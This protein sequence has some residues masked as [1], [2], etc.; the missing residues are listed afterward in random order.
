MH[1]YRPAN[2]IFDGPI[3]NLL[4]ILCI[5][6]TVHT[7]HTVLTRM[8]KKALMVQIWHFHW[9][10]SERRRSKHGSERVNGKF[11][12]IQG[13]R[14]SP[15]VRTG[16]TKAP[17]WSLRALLRTL[18]LDAIR[19]HKRW[20]A[21][22]E[23]VIKPKIVSLVESPRWG[24]TSPGVDSKWSSQLR[25]VIW[26]GSPEDDPRTVEVLFNSPSPPFYCCGF[27]FLLLQNTSTL[28]S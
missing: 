23:V 20:Y 27:C 12:S 26:P 17:Q 24:T 15:A 28:P 6:N 2:N 3:T 11:R 9:S 25:P 1:T 10:F 5:L 18:K 4:S 16:N 21:Q 7:V 8:G 14:N 22:P 19:K 13:A